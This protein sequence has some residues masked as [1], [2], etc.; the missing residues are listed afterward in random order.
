MTDEHAAITAPIPEVKKREPVTSPSGKYVLQVSSRA[1][2]PGCWN[3][4]TG[5]VT[6]AGTG[7]AIATVDR[8]YSSFP[9][10][11]VEGHP[12]G[13][14]YLVCGAN[15]QGQ[16]VI[17][18][19][20]G[21]RKDFL[22]EDAKKGHGFCWVQY[23]FD[24][25]LKM[26]VVNGCIWACPY[27]TRFYDFADPM[28]KGWEELEFPEGLYADDCEKP[29]EISADGKIRIFETRCLNEDDEGED[30]EVSVVV[31]HTTY[32]RE[33]MKLLFV[34][35]WVEPNEQIRRDEREAA[36]A[37][38]EAAWEEYK[39]TDPYYLRFK[40]RFKEAGIPVEFGVVSIGQC[41]DSWCPTFKGSDSRVCVRLTYGKV[42]NGVKLSVEI[43]WGKKEAP[44]L[45]SIYRDSVKEDIWYERSM[46]NFDRALDAGLKLL[47]E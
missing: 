11:W 8:N 24:P 21:K 18:L 23:H 40:E 6:R 22:P 7:E 4:T 16:T 12:N 9:Y 28:E 5:E 38:Y 19:D 14:D 43:E 46:E 17:E 36:N 1:T 47:A 33:G 39:A 15:Y 29:P 31:A 10:A 41:H 27:E 13:H 32:R 3:Y 20:T 25:I 34:E 37:R 35:K 30:E 42:V 2:K 45:L 44:I 26:M